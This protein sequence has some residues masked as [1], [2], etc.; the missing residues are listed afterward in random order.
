MKGRL[1]TVKKKDDPVVRDE[2][3]EADK[4]RSALDTLTKEQ[5]ANIWKGQEVGV[6]RDGAEI[7]LPSV[8][9]DMTYD[10]GI[11]VLNRI[12]AEEAQVFEVKEIIRGIPWDAAVATYKAM[13]E[14]YG[15]VTSTTTM[16]FWGPNH[17]EFLSVRTGPASTDILQIPVG[18][19]MLPN[20]KTTYQFGI[21]ADGAYLT[22]KVNKRDRERLVEISTRAQEIMREGSIYNGHAI[23]IDALPDGKL[24]MSKQPTFIDLSTVSS[25]DMIHNEIA[26]QLIDTN[27]ISPLR[28][29]AQCRKHGIPLKRGVLLEGPYGTGK[30]LTALVTAKVAT[31]NG[32]TFIML[33][34]ANALQA[35]FTFSKLI[36][37][38][39][40]FT[41]DMDRH[42]DR[43]NE[44]VNDLVNT[45]DGLDTKSNEVLVVV[46]TN[47]IEKFDKALLR[48]GRFDAVISLLPP[49]PKTVMRLVR[50]YAGEKLEPVT[51]K[52]EAGMRELG[53]V[54]A[55]QVPASIR[56]V[57]K[58]AHLANMQRGSEII[59]VKDMVAAA[60]G[61]TR[62]F[63][64]LADKK[65]VPSK[66]EVLHETMKTLTRDATSD[67]EDRVTKV[68]NFSRELAKRLGMETKTLD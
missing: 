29:T 21:F 51:V 63:E 4:L 15:V 20:S 47:H 39:V 25:S 30:T 61:M 11:E 19:L 50:K 43:T 48:P 34:R 6:R 60:V 42:A 62:H 28:N 57:V 8:P 32:W 5:R 24:D 58:R 66:A 35:A 26:E 40:I 31:E 18:A 55:G 49:D 54:L 16:G 10:E 36:Q 64:L 67:I 59:L 12:K 65:G 13:R 9:L 14:I 7:I 38:V 53:G 46:T 68:V 22:G 33:N 1:M 17:P 3:L 52:T 2:A 27:I 56:E 41:E 45:L 23:R 37:P 44:Q